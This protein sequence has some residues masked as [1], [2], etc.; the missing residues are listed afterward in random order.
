MTAELGLTEREGTWQRQ[1][2]RGWGRY[3]VLR[4]GG[5]GLAGVQGAQV[6]VVGTEEMGPGQCGQLGPG[7]EGPPP[8]SA[9]WPV[10]ANEDGGRG[11]GSG[12]QAGVWLQKMDSRE[13]YRSAT[14]E[15]TDWR[16][17][18]MEPQ[19]AVALVSRQEIMK[20][21]METVSRE[22]KEGSDL[23]GICEGKLRRKWVA[24]C[25][26]GPRGE[27]GQGAFEL[28]SLGGVEGINQREEGQEGGQRRG[29]EG[30]WVQLGRVKS[31]CL[32]TS[33][34]DA[35][36]ICRPL[37]LQHARTPQFFKV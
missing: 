7:R 21:R 32:W 37:H 5:C 16:A 1:R 9:V 2:P 13:D 12:M 29:G 27:G 19:E 20:A 14:T 8:C 4:I 3:R 18:R 34:G 25:Q 17:G 15:E 33:S 22:R 31:A 23:G 30:P 6:G 11:W 36:D 24:V 10:P 26:W 28:H 35:R